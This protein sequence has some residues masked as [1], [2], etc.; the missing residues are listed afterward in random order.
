MVNAHSQLP[1][2]SSSNLISRNEKYIKSHGLIKCQNVA[3]KMENRIFEFAESF[4][5]YNH[6]TM[7]Q[8]EMLQGWNKMSVPSAW[9]KEMDG[10]LIAKFPP[11]DPPLVALHYQ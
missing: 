5:S 11:P 7:L 2:F 10:L 1:L 4:E 6:L 3:F 8:I 9:K